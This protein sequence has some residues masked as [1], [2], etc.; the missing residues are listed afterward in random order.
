MN[1]TKALIISGMFFLKLSLSFAQTTATYDEVINK[2]KKGQIDKYITQNGEEFEVGDTILLG[3]AFRNEQFD[4]ILQN[5]GISYYPLP[6]T[7][8]NSEVVIKKM[9]I[10]ARTL[11]VNTTKP[12]GFVYGLVIQNFE[13]ALINGEVKSSVMSSDQAM[14]ELKKWKDKL[15]LGLISQE[16]YDKKKE[17][18]I[19]F[20]K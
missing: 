10:G 7:A 14:S 19:K 17:E 13:S 5:A 18:L 2:M 6:N 16:E 11:I 20:I 8:S 3:V 12:Q 1:K 15:D 9:A 4:F